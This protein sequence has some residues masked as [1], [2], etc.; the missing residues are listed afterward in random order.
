[1][2]GACGKYGDKMHSRYW[3]GNLKEMN[4]RPRRR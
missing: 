3:R 1:M 2:G 4:L